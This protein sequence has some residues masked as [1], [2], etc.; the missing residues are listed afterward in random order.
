MGGNYR[1]GGGF[2]ANLNANYRSEVFSGSG[3]YQA[4]SEVPS[5]VLV[6]AKVGYETDRWGV[7][8]YGKNILDEE[9]LTYIREETQQ[10]ILGDP[11][12]VGLILQA[13]W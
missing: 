2:I 11:R 5:R 3:T 9:Y 13:R 12:V 7:Y 8:V 1:W 6:N 10:A 4:G